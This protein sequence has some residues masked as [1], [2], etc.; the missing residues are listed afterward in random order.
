MP[1]TSRT[2]TRITCT[3]AR[4]ALIA[5]YCRILRARFPKIDYL[6]CGFGGASYFPNCIHVPGKDDLAVA[7]AREAFFL[8]NFAL[9]ARLLRP[10]LAFPF[11]AH[12]V[13]PHDQTWWISQSRLQMEAPAQ[14]VRR[15]A[16]EVPTYDLHPGDSVENGRIHA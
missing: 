2:P 15:L 16:P 7:R 4:C 6:F 3:R 8:D 1:S 5:E 9:V 10:R 11:A 14:T 12:F 13:L